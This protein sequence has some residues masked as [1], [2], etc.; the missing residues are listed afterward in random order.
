M[1]ADVKRNSTANSGFNIVALECGGED[2]METHWDEISLATSYEELSI[3][4]LPRSNQEIPVYFTLSQNYPNPFNPI[5]TINFS[6]LNK[7]QVDLKVYNVLGQKVAILVN[8]VLNAGNYKAQFSAANLPSGIYF[9]RLST[10][11]GLITKKMT[12]LK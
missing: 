5:T 12:L 8:E 9:Y 7:G 4:S 2:V 11:S 3:T 10:S 1:D 6:V